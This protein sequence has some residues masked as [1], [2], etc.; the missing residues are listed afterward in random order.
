MSILTELNGL[1]PSLD[2][3]IETGV[4]SGKA[5]ERYLVLIPLSDIFDL[6]ADNVPG[7]DVQEV[8]ISVY[9]KGNYT[10]LKNAIIRLLLEHDFT[11]TERMYIGYET[12]T[13]YHHYNIDA[14]K[15]YEYEMEE[16]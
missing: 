2:V 13:G 4:F 7:V 3:P 9:V 11:I 14:A 8:R 5:P 6:H 10:S 1:L 16:E 12:E 15:Y